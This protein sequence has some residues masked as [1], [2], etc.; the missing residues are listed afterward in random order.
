M[1]ADAGFAD[2][3]VHE[4]PGDPRSGVFVSTRPAA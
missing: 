2:I 1:L 4:A 3:T